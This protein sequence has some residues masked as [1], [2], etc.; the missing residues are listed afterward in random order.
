VLEARLTVALQNSKHRFDGDCP[1]FSP[2][3]AQSLLLGYAEEAR[4]ENQS[5]G[6]SL[7]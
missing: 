5:S 1:L 2:D 3:D 6:N 4:T 7:L